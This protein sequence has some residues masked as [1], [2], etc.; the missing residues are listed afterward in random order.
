MVAGNRRSLSGGEGAALGARSRSVVQERDRYD[1]PADEV[2]CTRWRARTGPASV[3]N[4]PQSNTQ[5]DVRQSLRRQGSHDRS[6]RE[7]QSGSPRCDR[8]GAPAR[9]RRAR[10]L[11][12]AVPFPR[13][14]VSGRALPA[15]QRHRDVSGNDANERADAQLDWLSPLCWHDTVAAAT[16][17]CRL[18]SIVSWLL[19]LERTYRKLR[20]SRV[21]SHADAEN[22]IPFAPLARDRIVSRKGPPK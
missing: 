12:P 15:P 3:G 11:G 20:C 19:P 5:R 6:F 4:G 10:R 21:T 9:V 13:G 16:I 8:S 14:A 17:I 18:P 2:A 22:G 1:L 7:A